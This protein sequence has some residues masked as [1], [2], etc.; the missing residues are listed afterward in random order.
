MDT[1]KIRGDFPVLEE[2]INGR[3][4]IY[5]DS[6]CQTLRPRQVI[7]A[8]NEYYEK[9]PACAGR[10]AHKLGAKVTEKTA[11]ARETIAKFIGA[12]KKEEIIF[13]RNTTE[14]INLVARSLGLRRGDIVLTTDKEHNSNLIPWQILARKK[15]VVH[16][17]VPSRPDNSFN[18]EKFKEIMEEGRGK[19]KLVSMAFVSNL[20]GAD[21]PAKEIIS[22]SQKRGALVLLDAAQAAASRKIEARRLGVDFLAFSGHKM[23]GP[24]GIGVLYGKYRLLEKMD[25]FIAGGDTVSESTYKN[26]SPLPPPEK[27]EGGLQNYAGIIGLGEAAK[28]ILKIG[29]GNISEQEYKLNKFATEEMLKMP[30]VEIIGPPDPARRGGIL[31]FNIKKMDSRQ[32]ALILDENANIMV[33]AGKHCVHSWFNSR[34]LNGSIRASFYAYN[35]LEETAVLI[36][37]LKK[38]TKLL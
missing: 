34:G 23:L 7:S 25:A 10:S 30:Q 18:L 14:G 13:T 3:P 29:F 37:C 9:Y 20:D 15:G 33:R 12:E 26:H 11:E 36:E 19:V 27:F 21:I 2:K 16:K 4:I 1:K 5:F 17:I 32:A 8:V 28:Y 38:I 31:S 24:S 35:T 22:F 6:A